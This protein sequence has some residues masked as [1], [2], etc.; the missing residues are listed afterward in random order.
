M[1]GFYYCVHVDKKSSPGFQA[2]VTNFLG[3]FENAFE[4][5]IRESVV[6]ASYSRVQADIHCLK[7]LKNYPYKYVFNLCGQDFPI[8]TNLEIVRARGPTFLFFVP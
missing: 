5:E 4:P 6:Y 3:C 2:A 1:N 8:K 7:A